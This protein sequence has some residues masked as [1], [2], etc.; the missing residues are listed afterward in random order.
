M[1]AKLVQIVAKRPPAPK[2]TLSVDS[3][4]K[5][6]ARLQELILHVAN[7]CIETEHFGAVKLNKVLAF[8][9]FTSYSRHGKPITGVE[10]M[11]QRNGPVP[12]RM[13]PLIMKMERERLIAIHKR[14]VGRYIEHRF[15]PL[16]DANLDLFSPRDIAI[17]E[18][19]IAVMRS[20]TAT[21]VSEFSHGRAW[22]V[23]GDDGV[24]IPYEAAFL[25]DRP[26]SDSDIAMTRELNQ[27]YGWD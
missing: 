22:Q 19:V 5:A 13:K 15:I 6:L 3:T 2:V 16:R 24:S 25:S 26:L 11:R 10:Y 7:R 4:P 12:R 20:A 17:V 1:A 9:D 23:A 27:K 21:Q 14:P 18:E 8:A